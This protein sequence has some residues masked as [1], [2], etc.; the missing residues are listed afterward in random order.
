MTKLTGLILPAVLIGLLIVA[1]PAGAHKIN[2][3]AAWEDNRITGYAYAPGGVRII[4]VSVELFDQAGQSVAKATTG[5]KGD[6]SFPVTTPGRYKVILDLGDGH[7]G[8]FKVRVGAAPAATKPAAPAG[9]GQAASPA[10]KPTVDPA[11][12]EAAVDKAISHRLTPVLAKLDELEDRIGLRDVVGGLGFII[13]LM[14][15]AAYFKSKG[16]TGAKN[17]D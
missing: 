1:P 8:E 10:V 9:P 14:G 15:L 17:T 16:R 5:D 12:I 2:I 11:A 6:F 3:F 13:G 4:G 7:R